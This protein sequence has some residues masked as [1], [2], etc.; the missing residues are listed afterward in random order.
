MEARLA[1][2]DAVPCEDEKVH[3]VASFPSMG[4]L[5]LL[6]PSLRLGP[7]VLGTHAGGHAVPHVVKQATIQTPV[8]CRDA[9]E[10][11]YWGVGRTL[12]VAPPVETPPVSHGPPIILPD[13]RAHMFHSRVAQFI[14]Q[15]G[16]ILICK[17]KRS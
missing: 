6:L 15:N 10:V 9:M 3:C 14:S 4:G 5:L 12:A 16:K 11:Y 1:P 2:N 17:C 8:S 7:P 13:F